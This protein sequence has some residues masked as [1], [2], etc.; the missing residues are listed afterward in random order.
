MAT[1]PLFVK[2]SDTTFQAPLGGVLATTP[3]VLGELNVTWA[4]GERVVRWAIHQVGLRR[5][6]GTATLPE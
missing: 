3:L 1:A 2:V 5:H 4:E 6:A